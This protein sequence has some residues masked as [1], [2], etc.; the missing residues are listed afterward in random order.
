MIKI[1]SGES[2]FKGIIEENYFYQDR[3]MYIRQLEETTSRF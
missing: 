1:P 2:Y 3:T